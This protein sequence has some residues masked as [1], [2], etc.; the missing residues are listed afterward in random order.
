MSKQ[1]IVKAIEHHGGKIPLDFGSGPTTGIH[2]SV[3]RDLRQH[4]GLENKPVKIVESYQMLGEVDE[5]LKSVLGIATESVSP[6]GG[7]FGFAN[8]DWKEWKTPWGQEVL[9]PG[10]FNTDMNDDGDVLI[11]PEGDRGA[12]PSGRMPASSYFFD[13]I[14]RQDHFDEDNL[15]V[16]DNLEEFGLWGSE[17]IEYVIKEAERVKDLDRYVLAN[18]GGSA[19]GDIAVVPAPF[20]KNPKGIRDITEWYM[21]TVIRTDY[22]HAIFEK[23]SEIAIENLK[24]AYDCSGTAFDAIYLCG[25]DFGTQISTFCSADTFRELWMP[26]YRKM[27]NWIHKNTHWKVFKHSCGAVASFY[28]LFIEAGFD[29]INPVQVSAE[30]MA[31]QTLKSEYGSDVVF[32]GGGIDTQQTLPFGSPKDVRAEVLER[33]KI[34]SESGGFVFNSI[35]NIQAET[36]VDNF[37]A[38]VDALNEFNGI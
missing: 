27:T 36:P 10:M 14:I 26:Y 22:I 3:I 20:L 28:P 24:M 13:S 29:L 38:M 34:F 12:E 1:D 18:F 15:N 31:P 5:E 23:Q 35:H 30:G 21:S 33:C 6:R 4:F 17:D 11:Y 25:T 19:L 2:C 9:V 16:E 37:I 7:M 8:E 32:W